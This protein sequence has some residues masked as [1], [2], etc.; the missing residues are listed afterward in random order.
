MVGGGMANTFLYALG[1]NIGKSLCEKD[2]KEI[3]SE[4]NK[5]SFGSNYNKRQYWIYQPG[6]DALRWS[7]F[8]EEGIMG[9]NWDEL[10][11]LKKYKSR[12]ELR[13][14]LIN[15][16]IHDAIFLLNKLLTLQLIHQKNFLF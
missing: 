11:D 1:K 12:V 3:I 15:N 7:D 5:L 14:S 10:G 13:E 4:Y 8:Y 2:L 16:F 6:K 9:I